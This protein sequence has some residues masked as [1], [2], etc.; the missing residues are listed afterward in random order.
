MLWIEAE[1]Q[2]VEEAPP[3]AGAFG[4]E[5]IHLRRQPDEARELRQLG[6]G[7]R[8]RAIDADDAAL[9][10]LARSIAA[11]ADLDQSIGGRELDRE[12]PGTAR[13]CDDRS[14]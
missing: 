8:R 6:L 7:L 9:A 3:R 11:G 10:A 1:H 5:A 12:R 4:E 13:R 14:R 2:P